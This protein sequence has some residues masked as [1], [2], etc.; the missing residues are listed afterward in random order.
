M[1]DLHKVKVEDV[2]HAH[3]YTGSQS[4]YPDSNMRQQGNKQI[5][6]NIV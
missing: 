2:T 1:G 3:A 6:A 4:Q 5:G